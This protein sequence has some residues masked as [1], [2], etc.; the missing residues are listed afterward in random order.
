MKAMDSVKNYNYLIGERFR[1][2][3]EMKELKQDYMAEKLGISSGHYSN[4]ENGRRTCSIP[5]FIEICRILEASPDELL[6]DCFPLEFQQN[7][8]LVV[9]MNKSYNEK[10]R[11]FLYGMQRLFDKYLG[12]GKI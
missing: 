5:L 8:T 9:E 6:C 1:R 12:G 4:I 7:R 2:V 11:D 10:E 3:R